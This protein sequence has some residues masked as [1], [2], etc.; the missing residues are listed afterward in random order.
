M[1]ARVL[2]RAV[3]MDAAVSAAAE[4]LEG[5]RYPV[6]AG[7]GTDVAGIRAAIALARRLRCAFDHLASD[8]VLADLAVM[9][10]GG[11]MCVS[12][13]EVSRNCDLLLLVGNDLEPETFDFP[14]R[15]ATVARVSGR[16]IAGDLALL[17]ALV[18]ETRSRVLK[19]PPRLKA[20]AR[21]LRQAKFGTAVWRPGT[22]DEPV[23]EMLM[24]L[25]RDLNAATRFSALPLAVAAN[26]TGA[27]L[28]S[29]WTAGLPLRTGFGSGE[30][31]HDPWS[32]DAGRLVASGEADAVLWINSFDA[33]IPAWLRHVPAVALVRPGGHGKNQPHVLIEVGE[34]GVD[35]DAVLY[36]GATGALGAVTASA[37]SAAPQCEGVLNR[38]A[39]A[40]TAGETTQ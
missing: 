32:C 8:A 14:V 17:R 16:G 10:R 29:G 12:P 7:L 38:I 13:A 9:Q 20:M 37:P 19:A 30:A 24:G 1:E 21:Q 11:W 3:G 4:V 25:V 6:V 35:H 31:E 26:G 18:G 40:I 33:A 28:V 5:A 39:A 34:P 23:V 15:S 27:N 2:G 36:R 22:L